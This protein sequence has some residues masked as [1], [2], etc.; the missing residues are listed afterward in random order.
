MTRSHWRCLPLQ[1]KQQ[2]SMWQMQTNAA[3]RDQS[4]YASASVNLSQARLGTTS[5]H[6]SH[7]T[8]WTFVLQ[9]LHA[10]G[11]IQPKLKSG[12]SRHLSDDVPSQLIKHMKSVSNNIN[13]FNL[14]VHDQ[15]TK[16]ASY[17]VIQKEDLDTGLM[18]TYR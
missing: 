9:V 4:T 10:Q 16:L 8:R 11:S 3:P 18:A 13:T 5:I 2:D 14:Y 15:L 6:Q 17:A 7:Q 12:S 1:Q